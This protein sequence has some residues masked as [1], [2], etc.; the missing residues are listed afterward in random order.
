MVRAFFS[1]RQAANFFAPFYEPSL[2]MGSSPEEQLARMRKADGTFG[3]VGYAVYATA[4]G[5]SAVTVTMVS[6][7]GDAPGFADA[8]PLG[9]VGAFLGRTNESLPVLDRPLMV[10]VEMAG[11]LLA[12]RLTAGQRR[13]AERYAAGDASLPP[14]S[15]APEDAAAPVPDAAGWQEHLRA[16]LSDALRLTGGRGMAVFVTDGE[17]PPAAGRH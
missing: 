1:A 8:V 17:P 2:S 13:W 16:V 3:S 15:R 6:A 9:E 11:D 7:S 10:P 12:G 5:R 4:D 14:P